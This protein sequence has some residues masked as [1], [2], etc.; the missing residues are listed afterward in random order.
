MWRVQWESA[1]LSYILPWEIDNSIHAML[2]LSVRLCK[3]INFN[4][5]NIRLMISLLRSDELSLIWPNH[6]KWLVCDLFIYFGEPW[7]PL[8]RERDH[9]CFCLCRV[10]VLFCTIS[11]FN[12]GLVILLS[13]IL[14][15]EDNDSCEKWPWDTANAACFG[16]SCENWVFWHCEGIL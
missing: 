16:Y 7:F 3:S 10:A 2:Y 9:S 8:V 1:A 4:Y 11:T 6:L 12:C 13:R 15:V 5:L 14:W